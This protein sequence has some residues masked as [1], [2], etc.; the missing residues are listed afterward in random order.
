MIERIT[1]QTLYASRW[2]LAPIYLGLSFG[3]I[4]LGIKFFQEIIHT[5]PIIFSLTENQVVLLILS[6]VDMSLVGGLLV[7]V[8][9][10]YRRKEWIREITM[11]VS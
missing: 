10:P 5:L 3:L 2:L 9:N 7:M 1:E 8:T 6:L 4:I 11:I